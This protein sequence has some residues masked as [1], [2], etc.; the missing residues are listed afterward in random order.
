[1]Y[2]TCLIRVRRNASFAASAGLNTTLKLLL[3]ATR[4]VSACSSPAVGTGKLCRPALISC[5]L[6]WFVPRHFESFS[7][8]NPRHEPGFGPVG[9]L[10]FTTYA[11]FP[12]ELKLIEFGYQPVGINPIT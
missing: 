12:S 10:P 6:Y 1:M 11:N 3:V 5:R 8:V 4:C 9:D 7:G 2:I